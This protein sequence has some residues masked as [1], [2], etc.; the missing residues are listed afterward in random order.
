[1]DTTDNSG[2]SQNVQT[3]STQE[4]SLMDLNNIKLDY[5]HTVLTPDYLENMINGKNDAVTNPQGNGNQ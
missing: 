5:K 3:E 1:M 2:Q 4:L